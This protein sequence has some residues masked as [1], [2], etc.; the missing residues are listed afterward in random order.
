M[1]LQGRV[2][3]ARVPE[4]VL[5]RESEW[6][7]DCELVLNQLRLIFKQEQALIVRSSFSG[8]DV[9]GM[10]N[11]GRF[12][13]VR[14]T[15]Q[16][17]LSEAIFRVFD[18]YGEHYG[19]EEVF[20]QPVVHSVEASGVLFTHD[21]KTGAPYVI[22]NWSDSG[23]TDDVTSGKAAQTWVE[24][25]LPDS[26]LPGKLA[27]LSPLIKELAVLFGGI[28][29]DIEW[30]TVRNGATTTV[31]LLQVRELLI[32]QRLKSPTEVTDLIGVASD[33]L[34]NHF[35]R[36]PFLCGERTVLGV[37]P[38]W[39]PAEIIG[40]RPRPLALSLYRELVTDSIWAYQRHNYGYR[41]LRGLPL[42]THIFG[43]PYIDVRTSFNSL[44]PSDLSVELAEKLANFYINKLKI[45]PH[46][47]DKIEFDIAFSGFNFETDS[48]IEELPSNQ[49]SSAEKSALRASLLRLTNRLL[50]TTNSEWYR[51]LARI[52]SLQPRCDA[53]LSSSVPLQTKI[54]G[55]IE[56]IK[57]YGTLP[58]A[59]LARA[60]F[61]GSEILASLKTKGV[62]SQAEYTSFL[63]SIETV[64]KKMVVDKSRLDRAAF[65]REYGHLRPGTYDI[66]CPRYD[67]NPDLYFEW[68]ESSGA[69]PSRSRFDFSQGSRRAL[70][71]SLTHAGI[72]CTADHLLHFIKTSIEAREKSK[73]EFTR[74]LSTLLELVAELG[75]IWSFT[76]D[77]MSYCDISIL[78]NALNGCSD[79]GSLLNRIIEE[80][81]RGFEHTVS[82]RLP[83]LITDETKLWG[84]AE[85]AT[86]PNFV[87]SESVTARVCDSRKSSDVDGS[88]VFIENADP[89]YDWIFAKGIA[90]LVTEWGGAN[91]H[92][93]VR[94]SELGIPAVIGAGEKNFEAWV[95]ARL[96]FIDCQHQIVNIVQ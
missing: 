7:S 43:M 26:T 64:G 95:R 80:G 34:S 15:E 81:R 37:M 74:Q 8:E 65:L 83:S 42:M 68:D 69:S 21:P 86:S 52:E 6:H 3:S 82:L 29:L 40:V 41:D 92:M 75:S 9:L 38:D 23:S 90:G 70:D 63:L 12:M 59:G 77:D 2:R 78:E 16:D 72:H 4:T 79:L 67:F 11:A 87:T 17:E 61:I 45:S 5:V 53:L 62:F 50:D 13:S 76:R 46:L 51:D 91:S 36:H 94:A 20:V 32:K 30:A 1:A 73:F 60:A 22:V 25:P 24:A 56:E 14:V 84:F 35:K 27:P 58:F 88:V 49:F 33:F 89:G 57:R 19:D 71:S 93:A 44:I 85:M 18:S 55:L 28:P 54:Y 96:L 10:S 39:N 31:Y 66:T 47:H 48:R